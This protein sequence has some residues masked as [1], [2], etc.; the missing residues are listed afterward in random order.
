MITLKTRWRCYEVGT[1]LTH[2]SRAVEDRL[3]A[4]GKAERSEPPAKRT[5][6]KK[7]PA[8]KKAAA[9]PRSEE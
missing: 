5:G 3:V 8:A 7:K 2:L 4:Q 6:G 9:T 1:Q